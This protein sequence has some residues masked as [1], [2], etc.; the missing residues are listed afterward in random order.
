MKYSDKELL[1]I[2]NKIVAI[3][4]DLFYNNYINNNY[5]T[6]VYLRAVL[7]NHKNLQK[8]YFRIAELGILDTID[9]VGKEKFPLYAAKDEEE[10]LIDYLMP[11]ILFFMEDIYNDIKK[12]S[13]NEGVSLSA[14]WDK[15]GKNKLGIYAR[16]TVNNL[17]NTCIKKTSQMMGAT[18]FKFI[19]I[20]DNRT[21]HICRTLNGKV[22]LVTNIGYYTPPLH[23]HCRSRIRPIFGKIDERTVFKGGLNTRD[24]KVVSWYRSNFRMQF[25]NINIANLISKLL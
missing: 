14:A 24:T 4:N 2:E 19:A 9:F 3:M 23:P 16:D 17:Y 25:D 12:Y 15:Y 5:T 6:N 11:Y 18:G 13:A 10:L 1:I 20:I 8:L 21:S 7:S 22:F